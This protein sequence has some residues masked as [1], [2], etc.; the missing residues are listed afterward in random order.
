MKLQLVD[1]L[2][3]IWKRWSV[4]IV[5]AQSILLLTWGA[6]YAAGLAPTVPEWMKGAVVVVFS[7]AALTAATLKQ[8]NLPPNG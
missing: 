6:F 2:S 4:K 3:L 8:S 1:D 5:A 7:L